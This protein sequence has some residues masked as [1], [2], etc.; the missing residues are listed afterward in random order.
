MAVLPPSAIAGLAVLLQETRS[1]PEFD[2]MSPDFE[3]FDRSGGPLPG[4][5]YMPGLRIVQCRPGDTMADAYYRAYVGGATSTAFPTLTVI[6]AVM[7]RV[8]VRKRVPT[9][10]RRRPVLR[11]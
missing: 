5:R 2:W 1:L 8:V 3:M 7:Q 9:P 6:L 10:S 4:P 11:C